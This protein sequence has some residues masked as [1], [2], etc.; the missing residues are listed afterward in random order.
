MYSCWQIVSNSE[1]F[2]HLRVVIW[3]QEEDSISTQKWKV[4]VN[5][6]GDEFGREHVGRLQAHGNALWE[7]YLPD[8]RLHTRAKI[9]FLIKPIKMY[10]WT[11]IYALFARLHKDALW[12]IEEMREAQNIII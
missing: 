4:F 8:K 12:S 3:E 11:V 6:I 9:W 5:L 10:T 1:F 7:P 2:L